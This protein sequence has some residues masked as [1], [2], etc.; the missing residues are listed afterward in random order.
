MGVLSEMFTRDSFIKDRGSEHTDPKFLP[1]FFFRNL[2]IDF[3]SACLLLLSL[4]SFSALLLS[5]ELIQFFG[6]EIWGLQEPSAPNLR[7]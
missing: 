5:D 7:L 1:S 2:T 4:A 3:R 6:L